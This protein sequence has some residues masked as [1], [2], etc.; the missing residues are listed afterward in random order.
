[1]LTGNHEAGHHLANDDEETTEDGSF[2]RRKPSQQE[3]GENSEQREPVQHEIKPIEDLVV[4]LVLLLNEVEVASIEERKGVRF[5]WE[6][7]YMAR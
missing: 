6:W 4:H 2:L 7:S 3:S 1:M 5:D